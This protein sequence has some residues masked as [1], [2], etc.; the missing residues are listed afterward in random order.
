MPCFR[1]VLSS[2][3]AMLVLVPANLASAH[4]PAGLH[5]MKFA[6][7]RETTPA[8]EPATSAMLLGGAALLMI[9]GRRRV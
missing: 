4:R 7:A 5:P 1:I 9:A 2:T 6:A 3:L 8:E